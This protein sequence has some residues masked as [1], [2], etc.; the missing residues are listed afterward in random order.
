MK[1]SSN[2][3]TN[4]SRPKLSPNTEESEMG[5]VISERVL[6][7]KQILDIFAKLNGRT[8]NLII[9]RFVKLYTTCSKRFSF[10]ARRIL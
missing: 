6:S 5:G 1:E 2:Q 7:K 3:K 8:M 10:R 4:F 9:G